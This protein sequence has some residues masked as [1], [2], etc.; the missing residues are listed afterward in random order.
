MTEEIL[1][2]KAC[3][4]AMLPVT[5]ALEVL[6]GK[7]KL[8]IIVSLLHGTKRFGQ[9]AADIPKVTDRMLSKELKDLEMNHLVKRTIH[10]TFPV[11]VEYSLTE[12]GQTLRGIITE[13]RIWGQAHRDHIIAK[14]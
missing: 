4:A 12:H 1:D 5:D 10:N 6:R 2:K 13:L 8:A 7:W 14:Q 3:V 11:T 9:I